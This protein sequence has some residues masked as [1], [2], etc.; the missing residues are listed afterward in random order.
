[1]PYWSTCTEWSMTR[2]TGCSGLMRAGSP[3]SLTMASRM[4]ARSTTHGTPVKSWR[5]TRLVRNAIS[6]STGAVT[7]QL[8]IVS[9]SAGF[10]ERAVFATQQVL[11]QDLERERKAVDVALGALAQGVQSEDGVG[12]R[13]DLQGRAGLE[14]IRVF[15]PSCVG[16]LFIN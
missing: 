10:H 11:E 13:P 6:F 5:S 7:F 3:P 16:G 4:A 15:H 2:S 9:M 8:A 12:V 14:G 1:M